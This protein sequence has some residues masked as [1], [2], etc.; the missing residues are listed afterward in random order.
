[1][2]SVMARL[3]EARLAS[4]LDKARCNAIHGHIVGSEVMSESPGEAH[5]PR[6]G[7]HH[8]GSV[9]GASVGA[10]AADI[11]DCAD[12]TRAKLWEGGLDAI[13]SAVKDDSQ[14]ITPIALR[15]ILERH[16]Y[17]EG[18]VVDENIDAAEMLRG[19]CHHPVDCAGVGDIRQERKGS[20]PQGNDVAHDTLR[21]FVVRARVD[22]YR[23]ASCCQFEGDRAT[24]VSPGA[25]DD[26]DAPRQL[27]G[28]H[29]WVPRDCV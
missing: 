29:R 6:L 24:D 3:R 21:L 20:S 9:Q 8:M 18:R 27:L 26:G 5:K 23:G 17:T 13:E 2:N 15:H 25:S 16:F 28:L 22:D 10:Q 1:M 12:S 4:R 14:N 11:D 19:R 7:G